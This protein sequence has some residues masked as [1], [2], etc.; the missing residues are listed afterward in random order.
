MGRTWVCG[1]K[2]DLIIKSQVTNQTS[3][4]KHDGNIEL[5]TEANIGSTVNLVFPIRRQTGVV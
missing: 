1:I 2:L 4:K 5:D 3:I